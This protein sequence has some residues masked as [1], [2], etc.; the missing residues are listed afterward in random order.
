MSIYVDVKTKAG[1]FRVRKPLGRIGAIHFGI[2][3]K[4]VSS[5]EDGT[6][7]PAQKEAMGEGYIEWAEK[8]LPKIFVAFT[9]EGQTEPD[10]EFK[11]EDMTGEDQFALFS[12]MMSLIEV[13]EDYFQ[14]IKS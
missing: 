1:I 5:S 12:A 9:P 8:V 11:A 4:Y 7:S 6:M 3:T 14:I 13:S 10:A 2:I